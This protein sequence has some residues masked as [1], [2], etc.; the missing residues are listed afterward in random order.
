MDGYLVSKQKL[1]QEFTRVLFER[2]PMNLS[3][4]DN[5]EYESEALSI[6][7][8]FN[9]AALHLPDDASAVTQVATSIVKQSLEFWFDNTG[10]V[11][12]EA[13]ARELVTLYVDSHLDQAETKPN[14]KPVTHV[15][16]GEQERS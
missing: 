8:R 1:L 10:D 12:V 9:E 4:N 5:L 15:T 2:N 14:K 6:L 13:L 3:C 16:I 7:S 11:D